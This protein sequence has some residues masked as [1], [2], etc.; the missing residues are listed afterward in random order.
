[1]RCKEENVGGEIEIKIANHK[2]KKTKIKQS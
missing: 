1:M 2:I